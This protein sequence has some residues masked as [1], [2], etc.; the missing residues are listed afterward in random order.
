M[1]EN[2]KMLKEP[3]GYRVKPS[4]IPDEEAQRR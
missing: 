2:Q 3:S 4:Y 1:N